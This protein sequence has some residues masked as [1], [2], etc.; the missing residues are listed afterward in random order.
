MTH[1]TSTYRLQFRNGMTF[2]RAAELVPYLQRLGISDLYASPVFAAVQGSTHGYD[3][4]D[5]NRFDPALGGQEGFERLSAALRQAGIGLILDIVPNHMA[6]SL[7]NPWWRSVV[8]WGEASRYAGHFDIDW[9]RRLTLPILG[10]PVDEALDLDELSLA[11]DTRRGALALAYFDNLLPLHPATWAEALAGL[12]HPLAEALTQA[13]ANALADG[14][15]DFNQ[16]VLSLLENPADVL[17]LEAGLAVLSADTRLLARLHDLQ[18]WRLQYWKDAR[19][20]LSY[21]RFFEITGLAGVAVEKPDVFDDV[22]RLIL[23]LV[24]SGQVTGLRI[25]H[26]DGLADPEAY[27]RRLRMEAGED[28]FIVVEKILEREERLPP[29]WPVSGTTGYEFIDAISGLLV[30]PGG[31]AQLQT[32]FAGLSGREEPEAQR[33]EAKRLMATHNFEGERRAIARMAAAL[34]DELGAG[35][36]EREL[37]GALTELIAA[38]PVYRTYG[39]AE[40][41]G[42]RDRA[43]LDRVAA[44][45]RNGGRSDPAALDLLL[46]VF[47]GDVP[48]AVRARAALA[49]SRFQQ[50]TGPVMAKAV[51]DTFFF[52]HN[53]ML[54][55]NEVGGDTLRP[56]GSLGGFHSTME[57]RLRLQPQGLSATSTHDTKRGEDARARLYA[58]SEAPE[59][60]TE[61]VARWRVMNAHIVQQLPGGLAPE[62]ETEWMLYQALAGIWP[63]GDPGARTGDLR[64]RFLA[65]VQKALREAKLRTNW[66]EVDEAYEA[67]VR[68]YAAWLLDG[69]NA[70]FQADFAATL[71]PYIAAGLINS[72][73]QTLIKL[74]APGIPDIYLGAERLDFSLTDPDNRRPVDFKALATDLDAESPVAATVE[75][76]QSGRFKQHTIARGLELRRRYPRLFAA[77]DY[78]PL[79]ATGSRRE[80]IVAFTRR[81]E[82]VAAVI[83]APRR[84]LPLLGKEQPFVDADSWEETTIDLPATAGAGSFRDVLTGRDFGPSRQHTVASLLRETPVALLVSDGDAA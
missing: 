61:A 20:E 57:E 62:A 59:A 43:L 51:E 41:V 78:I 80:N 25:D 74:T 23:E 26:I 13:A 12:H 45:V 38:Y 4:I 22:H 28:A 54:A 63:A 6:A 2:D 50:L 11:L 5:H 65:F 64:D 16:R 42:A 9:S 56:Q 49:R 66:G 79:M 36:E 18:P 52:R 46:R 21:R 60:W 40:G 24:R 33:R 55:L 30:S 81:S 75:A 68:D 34:A 37:D 82:R 15:D 7:Q 35:V 76:L 14:E 58:L 48:P 29:E 77:G 70:Q 69:A 17:P 32:T 83:V 47:C 67:A 71:R 27:L 53:A 1:P 73:T 3:V 44:D 19:R 10:R 72:L 84:V 39:T 8:Q 31:V